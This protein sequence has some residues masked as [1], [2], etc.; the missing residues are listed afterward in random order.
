V[1]FDPEAQFKSGALEKKMNWP[2][3]AV[4]YRCGATADSLPNPAKVSI[5]SQAKRMSGTMHPR[6]KPSLCFVS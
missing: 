1:L 6:W 4:E 3:V 5:A 2:P